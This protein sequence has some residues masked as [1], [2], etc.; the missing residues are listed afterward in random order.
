MTNQVIPLLQGAENAH[1]TLSVLLGNHFLEFRINW[2]SRFSYW[3]VDIIEGVSNLAIGRVFNPPSDLLAG[4]N[5]EEVYGRIVAVGDVAT[6]DNLGLS[7][8]LVWVPP[9]G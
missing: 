2:V 9:D 7:D 8:A 4:F 5:L 1:Q 3:S 6:L